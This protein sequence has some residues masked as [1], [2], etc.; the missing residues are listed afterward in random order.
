MPSASRRWVTASTTSSSSSSC[1]GSAAAGQASLQR[2]GG[3]KQG[4]KIKFTL[5]TP[6]G[7]GKVRKR[8]RVEPRS[9]SGKAGGGNGRG[10]FRGEVVD[11]SHASRS[12]VGSS[13]FWADADAEHSFILGGIHRPA[14]ATS[15]DESDDV[16][17]CENRR[18]EEAALGVCASEP[19]FGDS[20]SPTAAGSSFLR[21]FSSDSASLG[22]ALQLVPPLSRSLS[23]PMPQTPALPTSKK[24][25]LIVELHPEWWRVRTPSTD[26]PIRGHRKSAMLQY[27]RAARH[28]LLAFDT[29]RFPS[30]LMWALKEVDCS[31]GYVPVDILD[32]RGVHR[33]GSSDTKQS[34]LVRSSSTGS[35]SSSGAG[36]AGLDVVAASASM[37]H[38]SQD[39]GA[40][41]S[42][43]ISGSSSRSSPSAS[44]PATPAAG[45]SSDC[46]PAPTPP[47][48][49]C[50]APDDKMA[51]ALAA[52]PSAGSIT[53]EA[54]SQAAAPPVE[55]AAP[56]AAGLAVSAA[57]SMDVETAATTEDVADP[58]AGTVDVPAAGPA[59]RASAT[60]ADDAASAS[61]AGMVEFVA[62]V[63]A[64]EVS[65][66]ATAPAV[67]EIVA[68]DSSTLTAASLAKTV[69]S[70]VNA[71][72]VQGDPA[73]EGTASVAKVVNTP[74]GIAADSSST[75]A[76]TDISVAAGAV[77][78][79]AF[80]SVPASKAPSLADSPGASP[81]VSSNSVLGPAA[82]KLAGKLA[83]SP[84]DQ[85]PA[86]PGNLS[87]LKIS[88]GSAKVASSMP[89]DTNTDSKAE[90][91]TLSTSKTVTPA[92]SS[93]TPQQACA[94]AVRKRLL[95]KIGTFSVVR[96]MLNSLT[97]N[98]IGDVLKRST[99][100]A[101]KKAPGNSNGGAS[102]ALAAMTCAC[103]PAELS[104]AAMRALKLKL[105]RVEA[106]ALLALYPDFSLNL[107]PSH[108]VKDDAGQDEDHLCQSMVRSWH[109]R[110]LEDIADRNLL[111]DDGEDEYRF[112]MGPSKRP[113]SQKT[114]GRLIKDQSKLSAAFSG[115][116]GGWGPP[117][118]S[119]RDSLRPY[120]AETVLRCQLGNVPPAFQG[121]VAKYVEAQSKVSVAEAKATA[122]AAAAAVAAA[123]T[124]AATATSQMPQA[125]TAAPIKHAS[126]KAAGAKGD[127]PPKK[128][129]K[130]SK[131]AASKRQ[132]SGSNRRDSSGSSGSGTAVESALQMMPQSIPPQLSGQQP[133][134][135]H[136]LMQMHMQRRW[137]QAPSSMPLVAPPS[138]ASPWAMQQ[139]MSGTQIFAGA[140]PGAAQQSV[141]QVHPPLMNTQNHL[142]PPQLQ[143][144]ARDVGKS[145]SPSFANEG[146]L[147]SAERLAEP[148]GLAI[149][150]RLRPPKIFVTAAHSFHDRF[151][152]NTSESIR[153]LRMA[154]AAHSQDDLSVTGHGHPAQVAL[155][156]PPPP[157]AVI[158]N[159]IQM[160]HQ[161][162][163][164]MGGEISGQANSTNRANVVQTFKH[165]QDDN[166][167]LPTHLIDPTLIG[168]H[169][170]TR[171]LLSSK[172]QRGAKSQQLTKAENLPVPS[173]GHDYT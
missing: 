54:F 63:A 161:G 104:E 9:A 38:G 76:P 135:Q 79:S 133:S 125:T 100:K 64:V 53:P 96:D 33:C 22:A 49:P 131:S 73:T 116:K 18:G 77:L 13:S 12:W 145:R 157:S 117:V 128:R 46:I 78:L 7:K 159:H 89:A 108:I 146:S 148:P 60:G 30:C 114:R 170:L 25:V 39:S 74:D 68:P 10:D 119:L 92:A 106:A 107:D 16:D 14:L 165:Q 136:Q 118:H 52:Q 121:M 17:P 29:G 80:V 101:K 41:A 164:Q 40:P 129:S 65:A 142:I 126:H 156:P 123:A 61:V 59:E 23:E 134:Q 97:E 95:L 42:A 153:L 112:L 24:A 48:A 155:H 144:V 37:R 141:Q 99:S 62:T 6:P 132:S 83:D 84:S 36:G 130:E 4:P 160:K 173:M 143:P 28:I 86:A 147:Q 5:P 171:E 113:I 124:A 51:T 94:G 21:R 47:R 139:V 93:A 162:Q 163:Q 127:Q 154:G 98:K 90:P 168:F 57:T 20:G 45:A 69:T 43:V 138:T 111:E 11:D 26:R 67:S 70:G 103:G 19:P 87:T 31:N 75:P 137:R 2:G 158:Q 3:L 72:T 50:V 27:S 85:L 149:G 152:S 15:D 167:M 166:A 115:P 82:A 150:R 91:S 8:R 56:A 120:C 81:V 44:L 55:V 151:R 35:L 1:K 88:A 71:A 58:A 109:Y 140:L 110:P 34:T 105:A 102:E 172:P 122:A 32:Y 169:E 66:E